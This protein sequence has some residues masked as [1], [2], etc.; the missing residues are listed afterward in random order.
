M[1]WNLHN[2]SKLDEVVDALH[3]DL[4]HC[5]A[6]LLQDLAASFSF[7]LH[8]AVI[9]E[10]GSGGLCFAVFGNRRHSATVVAWAPGGTDSCL[11]RRTQVHVVSIYLPHFGHC[12]D[13]W[14]TAMTSRQHTI[15]FILGHITPDNTDILF[16]WGGDSI[17]LLAFLFSV[18]G[19]DDD[20]QASCLREVVRGDDGRGR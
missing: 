18:Y 13:D 7:S 6:I 4:G 14:D 19:D 8:S 10:Y 1:S 5:D 16:V 17:K 9:I 3:D 2:K 15:M 12:P 11:H 20:D